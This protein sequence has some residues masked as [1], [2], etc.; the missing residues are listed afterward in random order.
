MG[1]IEQPSPAVPSAYREDSRQ[2]DS[3][4]LGGLAQ[5]AR[6]L[7]SSMPGAYGHYL[8][9]RESGHG[10]TAKTGHQRCTA[11]TNRYGFYSTEP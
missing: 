9:S 11:T 10:C 7:G 2:G 6:G 5:K 3:R 8:C 4:S 1:L